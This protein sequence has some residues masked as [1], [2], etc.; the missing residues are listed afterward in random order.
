M[1]FGTRWEKL[2]GKCLR[3]DAEAMFMHYVNTGGGWVVGKGR[4]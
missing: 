1:T 4:V 2:M 3:A